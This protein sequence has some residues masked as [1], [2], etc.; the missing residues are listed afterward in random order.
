MS[1]SCYYRSLIVFGYCQWNDLEVPTFVKSPFPLHCLE[2]ACSMHV[3]KSFDLPIHYSAPLHCLRM[4]RP[5]NR[6][7]I[8]FHAP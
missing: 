4:P 6:V 7:E 2:A 1:C 5:A 8:G 3:A